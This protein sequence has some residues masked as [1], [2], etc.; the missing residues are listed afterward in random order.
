MSE[1]AKGDNSDEFPYC[2]GKL[3]HVFPMGENGFRESP[4]S[5]FPCIYKTRCLREAMASPDGLKVR[6]EMVDRAYD[7]GWM[8]IL[9]RWSSR[10]AL[11]RRL[12]NFKKEG[13]DQC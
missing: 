13:D 9:K 5:C 11:N 4:E 6:V 1:K 12:K 10:K 8:G 3:N 2:F 7:A